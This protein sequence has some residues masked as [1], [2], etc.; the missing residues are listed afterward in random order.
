MYER[1]TALQ[2]NDCT[3]ACTKPLLADAILFR[4]RHCP[5]NE[6]L[7]LLS[8]EGRT[9]ALA[10]TLFCFCSDWLRGGAKANVSANAW[11]IEGLIFHS[12]AVRILDA[13]AR[14]LNADG[15][16]LGA[17]VSFLF[18]IERFLKS[19]SNSLIAERKSL[20]AGG[21]FIKAEGSF[22][23]SD[24]NSLLDVVSFL[25]SLVG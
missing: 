11:L 24:E 5:V 17:D 3:P 16:F 6:E 19:D 7:K 15:N 1:N 9:R 22:L 23:R 20:G 2:I 4:G 14:I 8:D 21:R 13:D 18:A 12:A 10:C 25:K